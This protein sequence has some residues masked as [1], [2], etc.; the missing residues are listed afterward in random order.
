MK[1]NNISRIIILIPSYNEAESLPS[2]LDEVL[3]VAPEL[4]ILVIDDGST[5]NTRRVVA[6]KGVPCICLPCNIGVG[7]AVQAGFRY[8][9]NCGYEYAIRIDGDGQHPPSEISKFIDCMN[10]SEADLIIGSRFLGDNSYQNT[11]LRSYGIKVL[12]L[13]LSLICRKKVTDPTSGFQIANRK[14]LTFFAH[15]YPIDYPEPEALALI[16]RQGYCFEEVPTF[17][18]NRF[19]GKSTINGWGTLYYVFKVFLALIVDR[20]RPVD[21]NYS[22]S[23]MDKY[24]DYN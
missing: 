11:V 21:E 14:M 17:F 10:N 16:S 8:A 9:Y 22:K 19:A 18:R 24:D 13:A 12:A 5:D 7:G 20:L 1:T 6:Q 2:L 3:E 23:T 4:D 15:I